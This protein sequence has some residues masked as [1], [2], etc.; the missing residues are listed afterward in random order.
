MSLLA[1]LCPLSIGPP[2]PTPTPIVA[3]MSPLPF[4]MLSAS[5]LSHKAPLVQQTINF[6]ITIRNGR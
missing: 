6:A 3:T 2:Y 5:L 1:D 4:M